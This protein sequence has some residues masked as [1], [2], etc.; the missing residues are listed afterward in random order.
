MGCFTNGIYAEGYS[1]AAMLGY[2]QSNTL[3]EWKERV[4]KS[5]T[6]NADNLYLQSPQHDEVVIP[7]F[8][9]EWVSEHV[10]Q[11]G[12]DMRI[13]HVLLD[14]LPLEKSN[15]LLHPLMEV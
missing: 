7:D 6:E 10:R 5:I 8:P 11:N 12:K 1:E 3:L 2:V 14:C 15:H 13:Y 9:F 4:K